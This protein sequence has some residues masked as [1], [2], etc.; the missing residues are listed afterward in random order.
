MN[1]SKNKWIIASNLLWL[2]IIACLVVFNYDRPS[3]YKKS[4]KL[5]AD[6]KDSLKAVLDDREKDINF[7]KIVIR[8]TE[9]RLD[10][11]NIVKSTLKTKIRQYEKNYA[12]IDSMSVDDNVLLL[13]EHLSSETGRKQ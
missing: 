3:E 2:V 11:A 1:L 7:L 4:Y 12:R 8:Y 9:M 10:T 13:S 5:L 6:Q